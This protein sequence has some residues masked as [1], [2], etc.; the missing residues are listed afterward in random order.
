[1][2]KR[3]QAFQFKR[4][5]TLRGVA[6]EVLRCFEDPA[7]HTKGALHRNAKGEW[8]ITDGAV[9]WCLAGACAAA[10]A[11]DARAVGDQTQPL[12]AAF[13]DRVK[14]LTGVHMV[15]FNDERGLEAVREVL[16]AIR[17][18]RESAYKARHPRPG[19]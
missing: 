14:D 1:M 9:S 5:T 18:G 4:Q 10:A 3:K 2:A 19:V 16:R 6:R 11:G 7:R 13:D 8:F 17:D 15:Y 12:V